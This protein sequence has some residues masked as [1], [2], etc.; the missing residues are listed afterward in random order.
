VFFRDEAPDE[1]DYSP[2][3]P[4]GQRPLRFRSTECERP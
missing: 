1:P 4:D 2:E 3:R